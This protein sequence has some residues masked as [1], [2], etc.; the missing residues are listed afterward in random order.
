M[1]AYFQNGSETHLLIA[2]LKN[3]TTNNDFNQLLPN[4]KLSCM[5]FL[6]K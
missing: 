2:L 1:L 5:E 4:Y 6:K 3:V